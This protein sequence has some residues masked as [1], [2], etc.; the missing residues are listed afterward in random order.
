MIWSLPNGFMLR[1]AV[2]IEMRAKEADFST[3]IWGLVTREADS[4]FEKLR[5]GVTGRSRFF[6]ANQDQSGYRDFDMQRHC[7]L[8][9]AV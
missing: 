8:P 7:W 9:G 6:P 4:A 3:K 1:Y 2:D 5:D